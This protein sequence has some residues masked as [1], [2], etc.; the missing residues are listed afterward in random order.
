MVRLLIVVVIHVCRL[1]LCSRHSNGSV[2][3]W[4]AVATQ[5]VA[6]MLT[7][8]KVTTWNQMQRESLSKKDF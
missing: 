4:T 1:Q 3:S 8:Q 7:T 6:V 2:C 5:R